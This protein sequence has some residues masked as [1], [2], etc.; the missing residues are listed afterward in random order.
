VRQLVIQMLNIYDSLDSK[1]CGDFL[2]Y[3]R[4][5]L[6]F[7]DFVPHNWLSSFNAWVFCLARSPHVIL[8]HAV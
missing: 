2:D 1:K 7:G 5:Y 3:L 6:F 4:S 8:L